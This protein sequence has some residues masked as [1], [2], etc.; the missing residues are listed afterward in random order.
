MNVGAG[1]LQ[2]GHGLPDQVRRVAR[3]ACWIRIA[4]VVDVEEVDLGLAVMRPQRL[5]DGELPPASADHLCTI[6]LSSPSPRRDRG[7]CQTRV[8]KLISQNFS[9]PSTFSSQRLVGDI[10]PEVGGEGDRPR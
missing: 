5:V 4:A 8:W 7:P 2:M 9:N 3:A 1:G 6:D 10:A